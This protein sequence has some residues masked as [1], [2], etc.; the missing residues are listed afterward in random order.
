MTEFRIH[1]PDVEIERLKT[2]LEFTAFPTQL[3]ED[4]AWNYG[5]PVKDIR[6]LAEYWRTKFD[7]RKVESDL[8]T[9]PQYMRVIDIDGFASIDV[10]Y[11]FKKSSCNTAIPLLFVHGCRKHPRTQR[12]TVKFA[13][14]MVN[15]A[16]IVH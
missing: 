5:A 1:V 14:G 16:R 4:H 9:L 15:R 3:D 7:W 6:R 8:N 10:H 12:I 2:R 13:N 11:V